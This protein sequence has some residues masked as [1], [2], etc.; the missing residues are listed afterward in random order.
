[1]ANFILRPLF[2]RPEMLYL[3]I[4][5]EILARE[6]F[7]ID[8]S[9]TIF[10]VDYGVPQKCLDIINEY[11]FEY[12]VLQRPFRHGPGA[13]IL[14]GMN[15]V[16]TMAEKHGGNY[17][18]NLEDDCVLHKT[19]F[20]YTHK[21][22]ELLKDTSYS[23]ITSW[24]LS[25]LGDPTKL[26]KG[27]FFCGPGTLINLDFFKKYIQPYANPNYYGNFPPTINAV[28]ERNKNNPNA[29]YGLGNL[30]HLDWDGLT[31]RLVDTAIFEESIYSYS[32]LCYRLLHIGFYGY[33][34]GHGRGWPKNLDTFEAR[35]DYLEERIFDPEKLAELDGHYS[36]YGM[37]D[38]KLDA[39]GGSLELEI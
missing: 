5:Y 23:A 39:W 21:A 7:N 37:F 35:R 9:F 2:N 29:K 24:G 38:T 32:S 15:A 28:N 3:S 11:P 22:V 8:N 20:E 14:E 36:D 27:A 13:N 18:I 19:Y 1:M 12:V 30:T 17:V 16:V 6:Y 25:T 34:R 26:K 33:N 31:N 4:K 10:A